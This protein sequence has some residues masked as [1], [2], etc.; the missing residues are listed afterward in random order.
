MSFLESKQVK[1]KTTYSQVV[2][3]GLQVPTKKDS[4][5]KESKMPLKVLSDISSH[6]L[7]K[8]ATEDSKTVYMVISTL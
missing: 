8:N 5:F 2:K 7:S 1:T 4:N 3:I 6:S